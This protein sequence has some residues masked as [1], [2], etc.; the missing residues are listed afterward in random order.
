MMNKLL[1]TLLITLSISPCIHGQID[2][3]NYATLL[4]KGTIPEDFTKQTYVKLAEDLKKGK[5]ELSQYQERIFFE[6]TNYAIDEILHSGL[7]VYGDEISTYV[8]EIA[9]ILLKNND[10]LI[11][12]LRFYTIKSNEANAFSTE[13]VL[14]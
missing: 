4:S 12:K 11:R 3:K 10:D 6:G 5:E 13:H 2:F 14:Y 1:I 9:A 8:S 7:V